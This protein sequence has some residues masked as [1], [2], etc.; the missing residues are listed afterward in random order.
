MSN[1]LVW[2]GIILIGIFVNPLL[3]LFIAVLRWAT[4]NKRTHF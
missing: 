2:I 3:G 4:Q 1:F